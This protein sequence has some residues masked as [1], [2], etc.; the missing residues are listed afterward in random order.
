[1]PSSNP[2]TP[3]W[4]GLEL[5]KEQPMWEWAEENV[6][7]ST[8]QPTSKPGMYLTSRTPY[9]RGIFD[10]LQDSAIHKI[11][12][13]KGAQTGLT[14]MGYVWLAW[15]WKIDAGPT[16]LVYPTENNARDASKDRMQPMIEDSESLRSLVP[17][18]SDLWTY[19]Q[20][21]MPTCTA[22]WI[23]SNSPANLSSKPIRFL[24]LDEVDK[25]PTDNKT[26][27]SPIALAEQR[28]KGYKDNRKIFKISTPTTP[29]GAI[30][31]DY[32]DGDRR[33]YFVPCAYCGEMQFLDWKQVKWDDGK[34]ETA[35]YECRFCNKRWNKAQRMASVSKGE[36]RATAKPKK[37]GEISFHLSS[38][39]S[40]FTDLSDL[41]IT[42]L[43][44]KTNP[45]KFKDFINSELGEPFV[46]YDNIIKDDMFAGLEGGYAEGECF[47][48]TPKYENAY[49]DFDR[50]VIAGVDVQK[51]Y[52]VAVFREFVLGGD[53]ALI[54]ARECANLNELNLYV[55]KYGADFVFID[56][57]YRTDEINK[58]AYANAGYVPCQG[59]KRKSTMMHTM[60]TIDIDEGRT[61]QGK[62][63][64]IGVMTHNP[65]QV[66]EVLA[67]QIHKY[68]DCKKWLIPD[69]YAGRKDYCGQMTAE[70]NI[71]GK[72]T[73]VPA[74]RANH[75]WDAEC[76][77]LLG[78]IYKGFF[79]FTSNI[80]EEDADKC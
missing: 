60:A 67:Y 27:G 9:V 71:N 37:D 39:Y 51:L 32:M 38:L 48:V 15:A 65:D 58:W 43:E 57:R 4:D 74:G 49:K 46:Q 19:L 6:M 17:D 77:A 5:P 34:P 80:E 55:D 23:G 28:T 1:M 13:E 31:G 44:T 73:Q 47:S 50:I 70:R 52:V 54:D 16:L 22:N 45:P 69:G 35:Q 20:Y 11:T 40:S 12:V 68:T 2:M 29:E 36:W 62:G 26:E 42:F 59:V 18:D 76:L 61:G 8:R 66:K 14:Q 33:R 21:R 75:F 10:A 25:Y 56:S 7:L 78:A 24:F 79:T 72:W 41:A 3:F 53:S 30:H 64:T 63:R